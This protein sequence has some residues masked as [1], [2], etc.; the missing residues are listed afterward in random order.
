MAEYK[1]IQ[2]ERQAQAI[3][4]R[5]EVEAAREIIPQREQGKAAVDETEVFK[6]DDVIQLAKTEPQ[7][8]VKFLDFRVWGTISQLKQVQAF[9]KDMGLKYSGVPKEEKKVN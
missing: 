7:P 6:T 2:A 3:K 5:Q 4:E 8:E 1:R 9:L